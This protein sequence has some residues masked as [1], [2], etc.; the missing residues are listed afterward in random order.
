MKYVFLVLIFFSFESYS[1]PV[2]G[3]KAAQDYFKK[4]QSAPEVRARKK[5]APSGQTHLLNIYMGTNLRDDSYNWGAQGGKDVGTLSMGL[6]YRVGEWVGSTDFL[7]LMDF[8]SFSL[9]E[10]SANKASFM[11][12]VTFPDVK[13]RFPLY[14]GAGLGLGI[15]FEQL[16]GESSL[17]IDY[18][19]VAGARFFD[20]LDGM[21][22]FFESGIKNHVHILSD[23]QMNAVFVNLGTIFLF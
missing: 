20:V 18:Q 8:S 21:G 14:F 12:M 7:L 3:N 10:G 15:F 13:S 22:L 1:A 11:P 5:R 23:G 6:S 4:R 19:L 16:K 9:K 17:S 2:V